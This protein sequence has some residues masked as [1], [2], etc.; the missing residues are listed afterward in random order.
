LEKL[1]AEGIGN[2]IVTGHIASDSVGINPLIREFEKRNINVTK[3][4]IVEG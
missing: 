3:I 1:K 4:G 2:L